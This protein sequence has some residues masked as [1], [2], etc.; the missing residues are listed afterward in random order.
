MSMG[1]LGVL[2]CGYFA[3]IGLAISKG[4]NTGG[5]T[6]RSVTLLSAA[7]GRVALF[8]HIPAAGAAGLSIKPVVRF[9]PFRAPDLRRCLW[10]FDAHR[11]GIAGTRISILACPI[12]CM[13][14]PF[15]IAP[16]VWLRKRRKRRPEPAGFSVVIES[17]SRLDQPAGPATLRPSAIA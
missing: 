16:L 11:L 14:L 7:D 8:S 6:G 3:N 4:V 9:V 13:A 17:G 10:E 2:A 5:P 12:W 15:L 1:C